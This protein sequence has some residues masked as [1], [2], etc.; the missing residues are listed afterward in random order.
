MD[1][2]TDGWMDGWIRMCTCNYICICVTCRQ[3]GRQADRQTDI[4][5]FL[6]LLLLF[7]L[8][9][10]IYFHATRIL[11]LNYLFE[12]KSTNYI[13]VQLREGRL[14]LT[15]NNKAHRWGGRV[16]AGKKLLAG[17][18][19]GLVSKI[20]KATSSRQGWPP[21]VVAFP[22]RT[23]AACLASLFIYLNY[24]LHF[25]AWAWLF[26]T[27]RIPQL[28]IGL[29]TSFLCNN[30]PEM[31]HLRT[32][33]VLEPKKP[34]D[35]TFWRIKTKKPLARK[36]NFTTSKQLWLTPQRLTQLWLIPQTPPP[37]VFS[38]IQKKKT[39]PNKTPPP[40]FEG[41]P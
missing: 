20:P 37:D 40:R 34:R 11:L 7:L 19:M 27:R 23:R 14:K 16:K 18:T 21:C 30:T 8:L 12:S 36:K 22:F 13:T 28:R 2:R 35:I 39:P 32:L 41:A 9:S 38:A 10:N 5:L 17:W 4:Y 3:T 29:T 26:N 24:I 6:H 25:T 15:W 1:G 31:K 33:P